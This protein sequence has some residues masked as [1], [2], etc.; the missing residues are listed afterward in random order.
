MRPLL[1]G[2]ERSPNRLGGLL[3]PDLKQRPRVGAAVCFQVSSSRDPASCLERK[4][5]PAVLSVY[6]LVVCARG[7]ALGP[8]VPAALHCPQGQI[9]AEE[10][11]G[12]F[13][14]L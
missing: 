2:H 9:N 7:R 1:E 10:S 6:L 12:V 3:T 5:F 8:L 13:F 4:F 11:S 14:A